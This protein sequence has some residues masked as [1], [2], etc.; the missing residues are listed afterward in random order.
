M[1][2]WVIILPV[3]APQG[4][5][6]R[7]TTSSFRARVTQGSAAISFLRCYEIVSVVLLL[8]NDRMSQP[9]KGVTEVVV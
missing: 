4:H 2:G 5:F 6:L 8:R 1:D 7:M 9:L 3:I